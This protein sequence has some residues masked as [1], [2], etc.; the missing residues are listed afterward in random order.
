MENSLR[1]DILDVQLTGATRIDISK[2]IQKHIPIGTPKES[3]L[4]ILE[5]A[6]FKIYKQSEKALR[7][8]EPPTPSDEL[9]IAT[10]K[11]KEMLLSH[12]ETKVLIFLKQA[13]VSNASG[14]ILY[15]SL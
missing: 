12:Y 6:G 13:I 5:T 1:Q 4:K 11:Y 9:Y 14:E 15:R 7:N 3:A 2:I 8:P 10:W